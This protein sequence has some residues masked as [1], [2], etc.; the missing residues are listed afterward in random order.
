M[1]GAGEI[2]QNTEGGKKLQAVVQQELKTYLG[3]AYIDDVLPLYIVVMLAH[4]NGQALVEENLEAFLGN[5]SAEFATWLFDHLGK[6]REEYVVKAQP[7]PAGPQAVEAAD[8]PAAADADMADMEGAPTP[9][10]LSPEADASKPKAAAADTATAAPQRRHHSHSE[11]RDH[12]E[13]RDQR[14]SHV[15]AREHRDHQERRDGRAPGPDSQQRGRGAVRMRMHSDDYQEPPRP[16]HDWPSQASRRDPYFDAR[17]WERSPGRHAPPPYVHPDRLHHPHELPTP[18]QEGQPARRRDQ[19]PRRLA[20]R[21][22]GDLDRWHVAEEV[23][24]ALLARERS[25]SPV[26]RSDAVPRRPAGGSAAA[27]EERSKG[28]AGPSR[29]SAFSR[30]GTPAGGEA[31]VALPSVF[32][33]LQ[34]GGGPAVPSR[35]RSDHMASATQ[36]QTVPEPAAVE[37]AD[38]DTEGPP[39]DLDAMKR[40]LRRMELELTKMRA[41]QREKARELA[42]ASPTAAALAADLR[43]V[44]VLSV[45][46]A[47]TPEILSA[48]F[49]GCGPIVRVTILHD[50]AT[51]QPRGSSLMEFA[52]EA[53]AAAATKLS[54]SVMLGRPITV[55][56]K[57]MLSAAPTPGPAPGST[58]SIGSGRSAWRSRAQ[59]STAPVQLPPAT[60]PAKPGTAATRQPRELQ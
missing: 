1:A 12:R 14:F 5:R 52:T 3:A 58:P 56:P 45:H 18:Q 17:P 50:P 46:F 40:R 22:N 27:A 11:H 29:P 38:M 28:E 54:G 19:S 49:S 48:H 2:D 8:S 7:S 34:G 35:M 53:G 20:G 6:H 47:A 26:M 31:A 60:G 32:E 36:P 33:R 16:R 24:E 25:R 43:S 44:A 55:G 51:G 59:R 42:G 39:E 15:D 21:V 4:G 57:S 41:E 10:Q 9:R 23:D 30:L 13:H 37:D